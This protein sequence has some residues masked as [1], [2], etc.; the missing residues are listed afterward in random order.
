MPRL[1]FWDGF[2]AVTIASFRLKYNAYNDTFAQ[3][4]VQ[5]GY[6]E[7][8]CLYV[9]NAGFG[10]LNYSLDLGDDQPTLIVGFWFQP[11]GWAGNVTFFR[12]E[13]GSTT[14]LF[15]AMQSDG[16]I[17]IGRGG[18]GRN[19]SGTI[20]A[21]TAPAIFPINGWSFLEFRARISTSGYFELAKDGVQVIR[22]NAN[23]Q[24]NTHD[25]ANRITFRQDQSATGY[26]IDHY[27]IADNNGGATDDDFIGPIRIQTQW[28]D[29]DAGNAWTRSTGLSS[30]EN[31]DD[32]IR[33]GH[34]GDP[35]GDGDTA[36]NSALSS[37]ADDLFLFKNMDCFGL[38][39]GAA[40]TAAVRSTGSPASLV[41]IF[42]SG[43]S[44][45]ELSAPII[46]A[47][48]S[49]YS[50]LQWRATVNPQT[51]GV[52]K[53]RDLNASAFGIR[54]LSGGPTRCTQI[55]LEKVTSLG[56]SP[57]DCGAKSYAF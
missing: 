22:Q 38:N 2:D 25:F 42:Q 3:G 8:N 4:S 18:T 45:F 36:Y 5:L 56:N 27:A 39:L 9:Q 26:F 29:E 49:A 47:P 23:T 12:F 50:I 16:S 21:Q 37:P 17:K 44:I 11:K 7:G 53:D 14:Q 52:W 54:Q 19:G 34:V 24:A 31:V 28:P 57:F 35:A 48:S 30:F 20:L 41:G 55:L 6:I 46:L 1:R 51:L 40:V 10:E 43:G 13:D 32:K 33:A 15:L